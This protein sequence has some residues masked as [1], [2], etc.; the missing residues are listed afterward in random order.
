VE[1]IKN[2]TF[3][4]SKVSRKLN[5]NTL[6][7]NNQKLYSYFEIKIIIYTFKN[8]ICTYLEVDNYVSFQSASAITCSTCGSLSILSTRAT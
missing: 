4:L 3:A 8:C 6:E 7:T 5:K 1:L 2:C